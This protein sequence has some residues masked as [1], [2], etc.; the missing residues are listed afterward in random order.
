MVFRVLLVALVIYVVLSIFS[1][2]D[3][4]VE[5]VRKSIPTSVRGEACLILLTKSS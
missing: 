1:G 5:R 2:K 4:I 3:E